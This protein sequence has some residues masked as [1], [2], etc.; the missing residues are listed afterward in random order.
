[1]PK[2]V[3]ERNRSTTRETASSDFVFWCCLFIDAV[4]RAVLLQEDFAPGPLNQ[5]TGP[6]LS[7]AG[8]GVGRYVEG[9]WGFPYLII[10]KVS[11][12]L[13]FWFFGFLFS[14]ILYVLWKYLLHI[15]KFPCH[16]FDR[17]WSPIQGFWNWLDGSSSFVGA[18][19][20]EN[21]QHFGVLKLWDLPNRFAFKNCGFF[22]DLF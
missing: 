12:F 17:Y 7:G 1:M 3:T 19:R 21:C 8:V 16:V 4:V 6:P 2:Q 20:F 10:K 15:T 18:R 9:C 5:A 22:L 14:Q 13:V 11:W